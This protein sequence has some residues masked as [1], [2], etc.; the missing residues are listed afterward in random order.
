MS[1]VCSKFADIDHI[2]S[3]WIT[4]LLV[5]Y[6][7]VFFY[8]KIRSELSHLWHPE[9]IHVA[10]LTFPGCR[11][12]WFQRQKRKNIFFL[13]GQLS[14]G[15]SVSPS[16]PSLF[17]LYLFATFRRFR[18]QSRL[19]RR[20]TGGADVLLIRLPRGLGPRRVRPF[21]L[22]V[23]GGNPDGTAVRWPL[24]AL[25]RYRHGND[26]HQ[27][28]KVTQSPP[29]RRN[30][31]VLENSVCKMFIFEGLIYEVIRAN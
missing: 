6:V 20:G 31:R 15:V 24:E 22:C 7:W 3:P 21:A 29:A 23:H 13:K 9:M 18:G 16:R 30:G 10:M 27:S 1:N 12:C 4:L 25:P 8:I 5:N 28:G 2:C 26:H 17:L 14:W 11:W 19:R